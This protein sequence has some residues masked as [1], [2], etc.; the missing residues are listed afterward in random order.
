LPAL[1]LLRKPLYGLAK[2]SYTA[3]TLCAILAEMV[4]KIYKKHIGK[5]SNNEYNK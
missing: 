4:E 1:V 5:K 3:G 2:T